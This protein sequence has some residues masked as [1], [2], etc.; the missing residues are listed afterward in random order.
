MIVWRFLLYITG[1]TDL[2]WYNWWSGFWGGMS[3]FGMFVVAY[4]KLNCH[5]DGCRRIGVHRVAGTPFIVCRVHHPEVPDKITHEHI[6]KVHK[7]AGS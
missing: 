6:I 7:D 4:R 5:V 3:L 1:V 2:L